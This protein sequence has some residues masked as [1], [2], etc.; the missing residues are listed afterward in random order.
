MQNLNN[1]KFETL[2]NDDLCTIDGGVNWKGVVVGGGI[3]ILGGL[4]CAIP[5]GQ[6]GGA[7][8][9]V[10]GGGILYGSINQ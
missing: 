6:L 2:Q 9:A 1:S 7:G 10:T 3:T 4:A 8:L 5:G